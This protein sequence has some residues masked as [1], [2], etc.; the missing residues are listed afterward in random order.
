[1]RF[2]EYGDD[3]LTGIFV[4]ARDDAGAWHSVD[5]AVLDRTS[6]IE[7]VRSRGE[8]SDW[9]LSIVLHLLGWPMTAQCPSCGCD[10]RYP[11]AVHLVDCGADQ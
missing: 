5:I 7:F 9:A 10:L 11:T 2:A 1:M 3:A 4:R 6:V 8:V